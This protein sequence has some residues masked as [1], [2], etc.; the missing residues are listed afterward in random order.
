MQ[1]IDNKEELLECIKFDLGE[2]HLSESQIW[3]VMEFV[4][5]FLKVNS[6]A[7]GFDRVQ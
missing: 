2:L 4:E 3:A 6:N 1:V 7:E 5:Y